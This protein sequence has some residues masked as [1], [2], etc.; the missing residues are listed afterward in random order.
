MNEYNINDRV[1]VLIN[2]PYRLIHIT[3]MSYI[4]L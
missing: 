3:A 1:H 2:K 4:L